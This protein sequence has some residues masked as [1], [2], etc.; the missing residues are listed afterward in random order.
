MQGKT[1][2]MITTINTNTIKTNTINTKTSL[3]LVLLY[4][5]LDCYVEPRSPEE[6]PDNV[7]ET[8]VEDGKVEELFY[9]MIY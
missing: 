4:I 5:Q 2:I 1:I 6:V 9:E 7:S 3:I 8:D